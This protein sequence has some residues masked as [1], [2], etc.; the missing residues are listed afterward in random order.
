[1][2]IEEEVISSFSSRLL[3]LI[4][5]PTEQ[6]NFRCGYCYEDFKIGRMTPNVVAGIKNL[7]SRRTDLQQ[8]NISWFGGEP[9]V[10][11]DIVY[12]LSEFFSKISAA[13][14]CNYT[15]HMTTNGYKLN[16]ETLA[17]LIALGV[18]DYQITLDGP[19]GD[20]DKKRVLANGRGTYQRI[21]S[22][23]EQ[24]RSSSLDFTVTIRLHFSPDNIATIGDFVT[25]LDVNF[26]CDNR[27]S[28]NL[29][30]IERLGGPNNALIGILDREEE[31]RV[32]KRLHSL[33]THRKE[34]HHYYGCGNYICYAA[35]PNSFA[36][37]ANGRLAKCT[38]ALNR[39]ANDIGY[40]CEDGTLVLDQD[41]HNKWLSGWGTQDADFLA[42]PAG[43]L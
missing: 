42:C 13:R 34:Q 18:T 40:L 21:M 20:H 17:H 19:P 26:L 29:H 4:I 27:F 8:L 7:V 16:R 25:H 3:Q 6:C 30:P 33:I 11:L 32:L 10:A 5:F 31:T 35:R 9:T 37:R 41:R 2:I 1:M 39:P 12:E 14:F 15:S 28:I 24:M 43:K 22:N 38:V 23:L 36:I